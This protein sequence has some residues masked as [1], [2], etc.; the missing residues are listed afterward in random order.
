MLPEFRTLVS[1]IGTFTPCAG[2]EYVMAVQ[3]EDVL[4]TAHAVSG[5]LKDQRGILDN[6]GSK[7]ENVATRFPMVTGLLN[8]IRRKKNRVGPSP[9]FGAR[10]VQ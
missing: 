1:Y 2:T 9:R 10:H 6:V 8:A 3:I 7:L 4:G 5:N